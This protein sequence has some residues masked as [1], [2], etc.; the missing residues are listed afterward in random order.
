MTPTRGWIEDIVARIQSAF[1]DMPALTLTPAE[2]A[3]RFGLEAYVGE[4]VLGALAEAG[5][6]YKRPDG[7]YARRFPGNVIPRAMHTEYA[8]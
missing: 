6:L 3:R 8:A 2:A 7:V 1:L 5:V 4:A